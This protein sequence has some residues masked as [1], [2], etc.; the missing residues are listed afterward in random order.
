MFGSNPL[1]I[2]RA[3][4]TIIITFSILAGLFLGYLT[5]PSSLPINEKEYLPANCVNGVQV[6]EK[7]RSL[8]E[9]SY[10]SCT[11]VNSDNTT[12]LMKREDIIDIVLPI[13][14]LNNDT[15]IDRNECETVIEKAVP[16]WIRYI[17]VSPCSVAFNKCDCDGDGILT[18]QDF[19]NSYDTCLNRCHETREII[20]TLR[21]PTIVADKSENRYLFLFKRFIKSFHF[22]W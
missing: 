9:K 6:T 18:I 11:I 14:D 17:V 21:D 15:M 1:N 10:E 5:T 2:G 13:F 3:E 22:T 4:R 16:G 12:Y 7:R 19:N 20:T 8:N